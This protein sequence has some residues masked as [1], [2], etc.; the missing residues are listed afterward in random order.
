MR[1]LLEGH[2]CNVWLDVF[3]IRVAAN[4]KTELGGGI[5]KADVMCL[6]LSPSAVASPWVAEEIARAEKQRV[7]R[8]MVTVVVLV[9]PCR[10]PDTLLQKVL[11]DATA[12][13]D[14]PDVRARFA[15]AVLGKKSVDDRAIDAA[16]QEALQAR[17]DE[18]QAA[19]ELPQLA[20]GLAA[21]R[22]KPIRRLA[23]S[24]E[25]AALPRGEVLA[26]SLTIDK[27]FSQPMRFL[28]AHFRE[29]RTWP[30]WME[31]AEPQPDDVRSN[32][33][34][35]VGRFEW[36]KRVLPLDE[37]IDGS[38]LHDRPAEHTLE[39]DGKMWRPEGSIRTYE[40]GPGAPHLPQ[41]ME[42]PP[43][44]SLVSSNA[45]FGIALLG[46]D[47][48][49][50]RA[51]TREEC[52]LNF[53]VKA[54][55]ESGPEVTLFRSD[56]RPLERNVL[57]GAYLSSKK[58][59]IEREAILGV[60]PRATALVA[61]E[62]RQRREAAMALLAKP[63]AS[64]ALEERRIV[65]TLR[66]SEAQLQVSRLFGSAPPPGP[67]REKLQESALSACDAVLRL[68]APLVAV[69]PRYHDVGMA[70]WAASTLAHLHN[71][72]R[73]STPAVRYARTALALVK[74][75]AAQVPDETEFGRWVAS[76]TARLAELS[77]R[78]KAPAARRALR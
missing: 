33:K 60:Y 28:F 11:L 3:D 2:G 72:L 8:G 76:A 63:E 7:K 48:K 77:P 32:G 74:A 73:A 78:G 45:S 61:T 40:G 10:P 59:E 43:L 53:S 75:A 6:L 49:S 29:G 14:S 66:Y 50:R 13:L 9:R 55:F 19:L 34:R 71:L 54:Q 37:I 18:L 23:F 38:D 39:L 16:M 20:K 44:A 47:S 58:S 30:A 12:G 52:D 69:D 25:P 46:Q 22:R 62:R 4:L 21:V 41:K 36:F 68:L 42:I 27:L 31:L 64:L 56:H 26:V 17:Q 15:R 5:A 1:R 65:A 70:Y 51:V 24:F 57:S 35:I 67:A